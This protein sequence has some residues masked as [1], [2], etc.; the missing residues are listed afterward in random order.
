MIYRLYIRFTGTPPDS[1]TT[2]GISPQ[3][4][5]LFDPANTDYQAFK[6]DI[7]EG[8]TLQDADGNEM[9]A[10]AAQEF[11]RNLP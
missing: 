7:A 5:F 4:S 11:M 9:T 1:A 6:K 10:E 2:V 3:V 8:K